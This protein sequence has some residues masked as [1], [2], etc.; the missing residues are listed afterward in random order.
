ML[1][2]CYHQAALSRGSIRSYK[3]TGC[4]H[5]DVLVR[6][7]VVF[8]QIANSECCGLTEAVPSE[9]RRLSPLVSQHAWFELMDTTA[10][11]GNGFCLK[12]RICDTAQN[13]IDTR[14]VGVLENPLLKSPVEVAPHGIPQT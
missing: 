5:A 2:Y 7:P 13:R 1:N 14:Y 11:T 9:L 12:A 6:R 3:T 8:S 4:E 10:S